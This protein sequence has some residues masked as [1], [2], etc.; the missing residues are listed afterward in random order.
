MNQK[1]PSLQ[2]AVLLGAV[3]VLLLAL[4]SGRGVRLTETYTAPEGT[5]S[6]RYPEGWVVESVA[7]T[8]QLA[9]NQS[10][11]HNTERIPN[12]VFIAIVSSSI[13]TGSA[14][15][16]IVSEAESPLVA[17]K[18]VLATL[19]TC[20][21]DSPVF[22]E[23]ISQTI[24]GRSGAS[25]EGENDTFDFLIIVLDNGDGRYLTILAASIKGDLSPFTSLI[26]AIA[27]R[28]TIQPSLPHVSAINPVCH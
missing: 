25:V 10:L 8:I 28:S 13:V 17:L 9:S 18:N 12:E 23:P 26:Y 2:I 6:F 4:L 22:E 11:L 14:L 3:G 15:D 7:G 1:Q 19:P 20:R 21:P 5:L 16:A 27:P 24:F